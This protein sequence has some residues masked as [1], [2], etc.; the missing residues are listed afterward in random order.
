MDH[1]ASKSSV[2]EEREFKLRFVGTGNGTVPTIVVGHGVTAIWTATG[3]IKLTWAENP[4]TFVG[5]TGFGFHDATQANIKGW[6]VTSGAWPLTASTFT[7]EFDIWNGTTAADL[8][9]TSYLNVTFSFSNL[10]T[11]T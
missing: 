1:Y 11:L 7:L 2:P 9:T 10:K 6:S 3:R 4:G 8:A 5:M